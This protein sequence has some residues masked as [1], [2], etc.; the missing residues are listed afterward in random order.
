[1]SRLPLSLI[2]AVFDCVDRFM[3]DTEVFVFNPVLR[4]SIAHHISLG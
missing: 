1:M 4:Q 3:I 2:T